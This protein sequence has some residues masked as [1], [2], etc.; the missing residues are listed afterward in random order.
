MSLLS[1]VATLTRHARM[2]PEHFEKPGAFS[3]PEQLIAW[4][5]LVMRVNEARRR[6]RA[7][8]FTRGEIRLRD[9]IGSERLSGIAPGGSTTLTSWRAKTLD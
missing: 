7:E 4:N 6:A 2:F 9:A 3:T 8:A 1:A 5:A